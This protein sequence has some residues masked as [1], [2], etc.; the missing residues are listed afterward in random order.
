MLGRGANTV[1]Q[2]HLPERWPDPLAL[3][4]PAVRWALRTPRRSRHGVSRLAD[5]PRGDE[6]IL[7]LPVSRVAFVRAILPPGAPERLSKLAS[8]AVEDA[9]V[10]APE[11]THVVVLGEVGEGQRLVAAIDREWLASAVEE[12]EA[13]DFAPE[14]AIVESAL[15]TH[16][17]DVWTVVWFGNGG[18]AALGSIE[19]TALDGSVN[20]LPPLALQLAVDEWRARGKGPNA[21]KVLVA[22]RAEPPDIEK[23]TAALHVPVAVA[24]PWAPEEIDAR[25]VEC[26][27][28]LPGAYGRPWTASEWL[29]RFRPAVILIA[30]IVG[31]HVLM[32]LFDWGR[33]AYEAR[34]QHAEME[35]AFR[36][37]FPDA[38]AVVDPALQ[39]RRNLSELRRAA[40]EPDP[41]DV[42]PLL[43]QLAP[44]LAALNAHPRSLRFERGELQL[45]VELPPG[46]KDGRDELAGRLRVPGLR[47][48]VER[49]ATE[50]GAPLATVRVGLEGA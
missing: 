30:A 38:K 34:S 12:L 28:L 33:L 37:A 24:G 32:T 6:A 16:V 1:I 15:I 50:N 3:E 49:V 45:E 11:D 39:M 40:G 13:G 42:I 14:R 4:E 19:A 47:V 29:G 18:F 43:A 25:A 2:L 17:P 35:T 41:A 9:I 31:L 20:G 23:W 5:V 26:P 10:S 36:R 21:V 8:F 27:D 46:A 7:V 44:A 22:G 48:R